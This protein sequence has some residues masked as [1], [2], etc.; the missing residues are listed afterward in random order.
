MDSCI[1]STGFDVQ[2]CYIL[3]NSINRQQE[4]LNRDSWI[5]SL[6]VSTD[7]EMMCGLQLRSSLVNLIVDVWC[8]GNCCF[9]HLKHSNVILFGD[10]VVISTVVMI[11]PVIR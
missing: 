1:S 9:Y 6:D 5:V 11:I 4:I 10:I 8:V 3:C 2:S 7:L